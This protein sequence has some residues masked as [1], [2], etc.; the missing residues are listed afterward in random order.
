MVGHDW[1]TMTGGASRAGEDALA[2]SR[3]PRPNA[4]H[5]NA[6]QAQ[7][8]VHSGR[9]ISPGLRPASLAAPLY[10]GMGVG[11]VGCV[12]RG[13]SRRFAF[14]TWPCSFRA[15]CTSHSDTCT[16]CSA[17]RRVRN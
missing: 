4:F 1:P 13:H 9:V 7:P 8:G 11:E 17:E 14:Q 5:S 10:S 12:R 16:P 15:L 2:N 6:E 3:L